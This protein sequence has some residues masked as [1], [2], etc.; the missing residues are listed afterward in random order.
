MKKEISICLLL[1]LALAACKNNDSDVQFRALDE[2]LKRYGNVVRS[3]ILMTDAALKDK[4]M[5]PQTAAK[6]SI[7]QPKAALVKAA[8]DSV[9]GYIDSLRG[10]LKDA[11]GLTGE[12]EAKGDN[13]DAVA[14]VFEKQ[15]GAAALYQRLNEFMEK[16]VSALNPAEF[17]ENPVLKAD[18][19]KARQN[20]RKYLPFRQESQVAAYFKHA[21]ATGALTMLD[22]IQN[23]VSIT[24]NDIMSY[25]NSM[26]TSFRHSF[27]SFSA[28]IVQNTNHLKA[29]EML[30]IRA[31]VGAFS[32]AAHPE[33]I[34]NGK[35]IKTDYDA[36]ATYKITAGGKPGK[37]TIPVKIRYVKPDG[38]QE[39]VLKEITYIVD[40]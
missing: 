35:L 38:T 5:D 7:W 28:V 19:E 32:G 17:E 8:A 31:G 37:Y 4:L 33:I 14:T 26:V 27:E 30:E 34:I 23:D 13:R 25:C 2:G 10:A 1:L 22:K 39:T 24:A 11:A 18:I 16:A 12:E 20:F 29:G 9:G 6:A 15:G 3:Q 36:L 21:S 40:N